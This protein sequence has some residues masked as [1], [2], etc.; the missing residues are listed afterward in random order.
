MAGE[1]WSE[2]RGCF[3]RSV[4]INSKASCRFTTLKD[5]PARYHIAHHNINRKEKNVMARYNAQNGNKDNWYGVMAKSVN[6]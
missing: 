2:R 6:G 5:S 1:E 3:R 4:M